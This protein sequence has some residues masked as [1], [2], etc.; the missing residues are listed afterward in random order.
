MKQILLTIFWLGWIPV[1]FAQEAPKKLMYADFEQLDKDKRPAS[2]RGGKVLFEANAEQASRKPALAPKMLGPQDP[3]TQRIGFEFD[4]QAPN[5]WAEASMKVIGL[6]DR[7]RL[8]DWAKTLIVIAE[9]VSGYDALSL[10]IGAAGITQV[11]LRLLSEGNGV[12]A[13]GAFPEYTLTIDGQLKNHRIPLSEFKQPTGDW[14]KKKITT[15][16]VLKKLTGIQI[17][18]TQIPSKGFVVIDNIGF[19]K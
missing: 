7:G 3:L 6:K 5:A 11:R 18:A 12:D 2:A 10:D 19:E 17:S 1:C 4:I 14:V 15:E 8:D 16:Q 9:D 13:G